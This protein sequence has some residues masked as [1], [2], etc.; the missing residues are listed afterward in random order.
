MEVKSAE[1]NRCAGY[2]EEEKN[3]GCL[4]QSYAMF[5]CKGIPGKAGLGK[6]RRRGRQWWDGYDSGSEA[7]EEATI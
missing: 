2:K 1:I 5:C 4:D 7:T 3:K 6:A